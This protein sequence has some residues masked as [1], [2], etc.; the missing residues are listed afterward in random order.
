ML[1]YDKPVWPKSEKPYL[2]KKTNLKTHHPSIFE[3]IWYIYKRT[4]IKHF[5]T[6]NISYL[7]LI[8]IENIKNKYIIKYSNYNKNCIN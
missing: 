1:N 3:K 4:I 8:N 5:Q 7:N 2:P 6:Y